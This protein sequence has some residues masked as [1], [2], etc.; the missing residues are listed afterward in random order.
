MY[1]VYSCGKEASRSVG[2]C[3]RFQNSSPNSVGGGAPARKMAGGS[4]ATSRLW[5]GWSIGVC[6]P[7]AWRGLGRLPNL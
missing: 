2:R 6:L 7:A 1:S 5:S 3:S 4:L